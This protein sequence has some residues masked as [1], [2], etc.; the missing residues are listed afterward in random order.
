MIVIVNIELEGVRQLAII[1]FG[2][3][4]RGGCFLEGAAG[5]FFFD[6]AFKLFQIAICGIRR[7][8]VG[9]VGGEEMF[10]FRATSEL[11]KIE[12]FEFLARFHV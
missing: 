10:G 6:D 1:V 5:S 8:D 12:V 9:V 3:G 2:E 7:I 4:F 11:G